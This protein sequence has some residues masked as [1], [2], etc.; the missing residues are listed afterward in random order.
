MPVETQAAAVLERLRSVADFAGPALSGWKRTTHRA[1]GVDVVMPVVSA[2]RIDPRVERA[3]RAIAETGLTVGIVGPD[4]SSPLHAEVPL[5]WGP[6][7]SF[8]LTPFE[9]AFFV[10]DGPWVVSEPILEQCLKFRPLAYHCHDIWTAL[11][12]LRAGAATGARVICDFHE[13]G[14]ENV[15]WD[16]NLE[17]WV[18]HKSDKRAIMRW[19][20]RVSLEH[21]DRVITVCDS[22]ARELEKMVGAPEGK[23]HV[24]RNIPP[25]D[26]TPTR[27]YPPL[28]E[29]LGLP[30]DT[31]IVMYQGGTGATRNLEQVIRGLAYAPGVTFVIRGPSLEYYG[32]GYRKVAEEAG[33][34][35]R[36]I[37]V[38]PVPSRDVVAAAQG[39][40][41]GLWILPN[42]S[43]NFYYAL[44]NKIFEYLAAGLP[45][46]VADFPEARRVAVSYNVGLGFDTDSPESI[47]AA[48]HRM[49]SDPKFLAACR[50]NVPQALEALDARRE[51][52]RL[53]L[54]YRTLLQGHASVNGNLVAAPTA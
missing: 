53:G 40:D 44:P 1:E 7:V 4:I 32:D 45:V 43:K 34:S 11:I 30:D 2:L 39:A 24:V 38:D 50:E 13:W 27:N 47:G 6:N 49:Q 51:W 17:K 41:V 26:L 42:L 16:A 25:L 21:A 3:A 54:F 31:F 9:T 19:V 10:N 46:L 12:G 37:L 23:V 52:E 15:T 8:H 22:I 48:M 29:Q 33:V 36:L 35:D 14:S 20:E 28:K 5:D 18:P